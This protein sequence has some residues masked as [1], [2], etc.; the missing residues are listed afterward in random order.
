MCV[1]GVVWNAAESCSVSTSSDLWKCVTCSPH[2]PLCCRDS[3]LLPVPSYQA[4][5]PEPSPCP[6]GPPVS[7]IFPSLHTALPPRLTT[8]SP[9]T[10]VGTEAPPQRGPPSVT[11]PITVLYVRLLRLLKS[12]SMFVCLPV[13]HASS[14][15]GTSPV[16]SG[17]KSVLFSPLSSAP[18]PR[19]AP[20]SSGWRNKRWSTLVHKADGLLQT[21]CTEVTFLGHR[22]YVALR[23]LIGSTKLMEFNTHFRSNWCVRVPLIWI[24]STKIP[25]PPLNILW[26]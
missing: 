6:C 2:L 11:V 7:L 10:G 26:T 18:R 3:C 15:S 20:R 13:C 5:A 25:A 23:L 22:T 8:A 19:L 17:P 21:L 9:N 4:L 16:G 1:L 12:S 14:P 24:S